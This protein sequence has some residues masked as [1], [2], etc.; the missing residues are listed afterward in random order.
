MIP[1]E[2]KPKESTPEKKR[3]DA[4]KS[5]S[6][7]IQVAIFSSLRHKLRT[8]LNAIIGY[9][10]ML[11]E[12]AADSGEDTFILDLGKIHS[13]GKQI[14]YQVNELLDS[15]KIESGQ[16]ETDLGIIGENLRRETSEPLNAIIEYCNSLI[17]KAESLNLVDYISDLKRIRSSSEQFLSIINSMIKPSVTEKE[18][19]ETETKISVTSSLIPEI[20]KTVSQR[21]EDIIRAKESTNTL[22]VVDDNEDNRRVLS[23]H[24]ERQGHKVLVAENGRQ[25][26]EM[27]K[28]QKF[29]L[30]LL[31]IMMPEM[32]GF[33]VLQYLK[34]KY[35]WRHIP[36]IMI[37]ALDDMESVVKCIEMGAED[38][39]PKPFDPVLLKARISACL[40]KKRL[41]E[42]EIAY[43]VQI[44]EILGKLNNELAQAADYVK[45]LLPKPITE[46]I[47]RT[48]W[49]FIPSTSLGGDSFGYH[50]L[51]D[52]NFAIYLLDVS[53]HGVGAALLSISVINVLRSHTLPGTDFRKPDQVL[54]ALNNTF[55]ME[56]HN[57]MYFS[58]WYGVFNKLSRNLEYA[59]AGH[60][61]ALLFTDASSGKFQLEELRTQNLFIGCLPNLNF[62]KGICK[63]E[64]PS[65]LYIFSDGVYE[66]TKEDGKVWEFEEFVEF[67][68]QTT[69]KNRSVIESLLKYVQELSKTKTLDDDFSIMEVIFK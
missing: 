37:S 52:D 26:L 39:L 4:Q 38:Y 45:T 28:K 14:L 30:L 33:Q 27:I 69:V 58:I 31:D 20:S 67:M 10:E 3:A 48:D 1:E 63:V 19:K 5:E 57:N 50:W 6:E 21:G 41:R 55:P 51:D 24:L 36:V 66:I 9:C 64:G 15:K 42:K 22:L 18:N 2:T 35:T 13:F 25:A 43:L 17:A 40:E 7:R 23:R 11:L 44:K 56:Q 68:V 61:P 60:P 16:M 59:S 29:D 54:S 8:P 46:G 62:K 32:N 47:I 49:R 34:S 65:R 53:G 12:D